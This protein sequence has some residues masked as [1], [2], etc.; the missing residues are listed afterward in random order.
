MEKY[1]QINYNITIT[2]ENFIRIPYDTQ[3]SYHVSYK[4]VEKMNFIFYN[5]NRAPNSNIGNTFWV[6]GKSISN[7]TLKNSNVNLTE[8]KYEILYFM[9]FFLLMILIY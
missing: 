2:N 4:N 5:F 3:A 6:K 9:V 1:N 7:I 8:Y